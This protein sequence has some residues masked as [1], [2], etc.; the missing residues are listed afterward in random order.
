VLAILLW[1]TAALHLLGQEQEQK[2]VDRVMRP[3][4][5]LQNHAQNKAFNGAGSFEAKAALTREFYFTQRVATKAASPGTFQARTH[6]QGDFQF[7]TSQAHTKPRFLIP[8]VSSTVKTETHPAE[9]AVESTKPAP[10]TD[11]FQTKATTTRATAQG[12]LDREYGGRKPM[13]IEEVR[14]LLNKSK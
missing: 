12:A 9:A 4:M 2:L 3:K 5:D 13:T 8:N 1:F 11:T 7:S 6:W 10:Y 14:E